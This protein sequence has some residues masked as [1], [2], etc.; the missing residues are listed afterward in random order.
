MNSPKTAL[1]LINVGTPDSPEKGDVRRYLKQFL[2]DPR[3]IDIP[4]AARW[5]L[6]R[7]VILPLRPRR[8]ARAYAKIW[9]VNGSPLLAHGRELA[10]KVQ[11]RF[12]D[13][14][15]SV[16]L[17]M[18]YGNP[19]IA[20]ALDRLRERGVTHIVA[21]PLYP[22]Y[23]S[24]T[25]G[26][27]VEALWR[28][29]SPLW[30]TP[31]LQIVPAF[32]DHPAFVGAFARVVRPTIERANA[33]K[34]LFSYHGLPERQCRKSDASGKHCLVQPDCCSTVGPVN[35]NCYRAQ[36]FA[37][38]RSL[39]D[40]LGIPEEQRVTSFQSRLGRT[41]W[42]QPYTDGTLADLAAQGVK[43]IAVLTPSFVADCLETIEEIGIRARQTWHSLGG[44]HL[45]LAP[46]PNSHDAW[47]DAIVA[48][49]RAH[50]PWLR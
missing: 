21:L 18:R 3:V 19:S 50:M 10:H 28:A 36:C 2:S 22:H 17:A 11:E 4:A 1:L 46:C 39:G 45:E 25:T 9:T 30:N 15:I 5:L 35:T 42:I 20:S 31:Y 13:D 33:E 47:A 43:R 27:S 8:S 16:E 26:S 41:K 12:A 23:S 40:Q 38:T 34:V 37:S 7:L 44:E 24:A 14:D 49:S 32:Y 48:I 6:L 29:A